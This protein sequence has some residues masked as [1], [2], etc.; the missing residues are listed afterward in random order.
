MTRKP[1]GSGPRRR[2]ISTISP[3]SP[4]WWRWG[5]FT[6]AAGRLGVTKAKVSVEV[7][8]LE[9]AL[10]VSLL[11]RTTRRVVPTD[12]GRRLH[13]ACAPL[14]TE[15]AEAMAQVS[16]AQGA[17]AGTLKIAAPV[18]HTAQFLAGVA[19]EFAR[20]HPRLRINL[21][22][23]DHIDDMVAE[24]IDLSI[25]FGWLRDSSQRAVKLGELE[26]CVLAAPG[27]LQVH[28]TPTEPQDLSR[29]EWIALTLLPSPLT[30]TFTS[31]AGVA[32]TVRLA[33]RLQTDSPAA[34]R[35]LVIGGA[36]LA[37]LE[38][39]S[40]AEELQRGRLQRV[41]PGWSLPRG[42]IYAV[43]PPGRHLPAGVRAFVE[44]YRGKLGLF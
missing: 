5:G 22:A 9:A 6:A 33:S 14:L 26:Q 8:R 43:Y 40:I 44:F 23:S 2:A 29:H 12:A 42:G 30:W 27:Y 34:L 25:R 13:Q 18:D 4:R 19:A 11:T 16:G 41:L 35:A 38:M 36:G 21:C 39:L 17:I 15:L 31:P 32:E 37:V 1:V 7:R 28:G 3:S 24:G 10:G 20:L